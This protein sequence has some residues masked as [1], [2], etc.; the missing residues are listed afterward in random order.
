MQ[1]GFAPLGPHQE[2]STSNRSLINARSETILQLP[3]FR[4][5]LKPGVSGRCAVPATGFYEWYKPA[6]SRAR[7]ADPFL[8]QRAELAND[9]IDGPVMFMAGVYGDGFA[10]EDGDHAFVIV[11]AAASREFSWLHDRQPCFLDSQREVD[12]W[13]DCGAVPSEE[14]V[15]RLLTSRE[16]LSWKRM[17]RDLSKVSTN[18]AK[19]KAQSD[20]ASFF[21]SKPVRPKQPRHTN[22]Q[23]KSSVKLGVTATKRS[24]NKRNTGSQRKSVSDEKKAT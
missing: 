1:W 7:D 13:L 12:E 10:N 3:T 18:Q 6:G 8:V 15:P 24:I 9:S 21:T 19:P 5:L 16:G 11:T 22:D 4:R 23:H 14:V 20:I 17:L 2:E